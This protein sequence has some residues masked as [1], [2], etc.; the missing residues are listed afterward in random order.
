MPE[1][2]P[3]RTCTWFIVIVDPVAGN[4]IDSYCRLILVL[5]DTVYLIIKVFIF[6][7][8]AAV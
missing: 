6:V 4:A 7:C 1:A 5:A 3:K 8:N 2:R